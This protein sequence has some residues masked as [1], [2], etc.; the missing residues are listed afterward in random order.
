MRYSW[1]RELLKARSFL[2]ELGFNHGDMAVRNLAV[3]S[4]N[5]LKLFDFGSAT[6]KDHY[7]YA[8]DL[9]RDHFGLATCIHYILTGVEPFADITSAQ[10]VRH[11]E[12]RLLEGH[13][14]IAA[15]GEILKDV[16]QAGWTGQAASSTFCEVQ[17]RVEAEIGARDEGKSTEP[18]HEHYR[19][20]ESRCAV[21]LMLAIPDQRWMNPSDYCKVSRG[22]VY[23][24]EIE[25]W[26]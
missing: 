21:W 6:T 25:I 14:P 20:L 7:D 19:R 2:E 3:D 22:K 15:G 9:K 5:R 11:I 12:N 16:I 1:L 18:S 26:R 23:E 13:G 8:A 10:K 17:A 24:V 4:T